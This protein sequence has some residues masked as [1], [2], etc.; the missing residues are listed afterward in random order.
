MGKAA[1]GLIIVW[2]LLGLAAISAIVAVH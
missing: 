1:I 2:L